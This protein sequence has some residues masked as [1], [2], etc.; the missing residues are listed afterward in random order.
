MNFFAHQ[1]RARKRTRW[2]VLVFILAVVCIVL[3]VDLVVLVVMANMNSEG[4]AVPTWSWIQNNPMVLVWSSAIVLAG[5]LGATLFKLAVLSGGGGVVARSMGGTLVSGDVTEP[6]RR[7]LRNVVEE[8][9]IASGV[10]VPE[11][12]VLESE[13]SINAFAAGYAPGDAAVA[14]SR[15]ALEKLNRSELQGVIAHEFS[16][17][18]NGD[19]RLNIRLMGILFG[20]LMIGLAGRQIMR[21]SYYSRSSRK[22]GAPLVFVGLALTAIGYIGLFFGHVIQAAVSRQREFLADASAVQFTRDPDGVSGA[23]KKIAAFSGHGRMEAADAEEVGHMLF[24]DGVGRMVFATHPPLDD[25]IRAIDPHFDPSELREL[26]VRMDLGGEPVE[27]AAAPAHEAA[28]GFAAGATVQA[29]AQELMEDVGNPS[30]DHVVYAEKLIDDLPDPLLLKVRSLRSAI[31]VVLAL[32]MDREPAVRARQLEII[33][34]EMGR[35]HR[36]RVEGCLPE[37]DQLNPLHRLPLVELAFPAIKRRPRQA[38]EI[39]MA[40]IGKLIR[41]DG[42]VTVFEFALSQVITHYLSEYMSPATAASRANELDLKDAR[43]EIKALLA[44]LADVG[45]QNKEQARRAFQAGFGSLFS[46][47]SAEYGRPD[48]WVSTLDK[49]LEELNRLLPLFK[50]ELV[51]SLIKTMS[52]DGKITLEEVELLR[53][54]CAALHCPMPPRLVAD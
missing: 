28:M 42:E 9:A 20:I 27:P 45:H 41:A 2:L 30:W 6:R 26:A 51:R 14:V 21:A 23:L 33:E 17:I 12:Y 3:A 37:V 16:H 49:A 34:S 39:Y 40:V 53:A 54:I 19:M 10:P 46:M 18:F 8:I 48:N 43:D 44:V 4:L 35:N 32:L 1:D 24:A 25:R 50:E 5:I 13:E 47:E 15:G 7:Q 11:V 38:L 52:H 36:S 22:E 31:D 29:D